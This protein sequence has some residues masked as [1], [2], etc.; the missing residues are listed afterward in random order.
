MRRLIA[1]VAL[2][3]LPLLG[4]ACVPADPAR[5]CRPTGVV[6]HR[7]LR[8]ANTAGVSAR[9]QSLDLYTPVRG[10]GC[11][12]APLVAY[13]HGGAYV[14]GDKANQITDKVNLFTGA[15]WGFASINYRLVDAAGSGPGNGMYPAPEHDVA[16]AIAYLKNHAAAYNLDGSRVMLLGHSAGAFLVA[17]VS[18]D[19][20][21]LRAAGL[22]LDDVRCTAPLD[23]TYDI[24][25]Q[26]AAGGT[27]AAMYTNA[28]GADPDVWTQA[29][30]INNVGRGKGIPLFHIVT[31]GTAQRIAQSQSFGDA[32]DTA[33]VPADVQV[34]RGLTHDEVNDAVGQPGESLVTSPLLSFFRGCLAAR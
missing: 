10:S 32:L 11:A 26:V 6:S 21:F 25:A 3:A 16:G 18:T 28:F 31:R 2:L 19:S 15:G 29:S 8:Y 22:D 7:D 12:P 14:K 24:P 5:D 1:F 13:V 30:P 4:T 9:F 33:G 17:L 20:T 27:E 23:T 34:V